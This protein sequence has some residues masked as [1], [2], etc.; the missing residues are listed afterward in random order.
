MSS[1]TPISGTLDLL[2][3]RTL[4]GG[5]ELHGF[6]ILEWIS[7]CTEGSLVLEDGALYHAL[8]RLERR[9]LISSEWGI[10]EKNRRAKYYAITGKGEHRLTAAEERWHSYVDAVTKIVPHAVGGRA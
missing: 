6:A 8:H 7:E 2:I 5:A 4:G 3:L 1:L 9:G 10:S